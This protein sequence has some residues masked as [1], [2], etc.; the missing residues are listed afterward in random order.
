MSKKFY[1][2]LI[3]VLRGNDIDSGSSMQLGEKQIMN[4][5]QGSHSSFKHSYNR[6]SMSQ[7][8]VRVLQKRSEFLDEMSEGMDEVTKIKL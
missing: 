7:A 1:D 6:K 2:K 5:T 3:E 8:N 4:Y